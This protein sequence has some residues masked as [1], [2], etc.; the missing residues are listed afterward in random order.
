[1]QETWSRITSSDSIKAHLI[2]FFSYNVL[3]ALLPVGISLFI[4]LIGKK[5]PSLD[6]YTS[7]LLFFAIV[8]GATTLGDITDERK[9]VQNNP[10]VQVVKANLLWGTIVVGIIYGLFLY[11]V[12]I[13]PEN[14]DVRSSLSVISLVLAIGLFFAGFFAE[15]MLADSREKAKEPPKTPN[16]EL[17]HQTQL[18]EKS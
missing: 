3:G 14:S 1:M 16:L 5:Q 4:H 10:L 17:N 18:G 12:I 13:G 15:I 9:V 8:I 7:D 6:K 2:R 11:G